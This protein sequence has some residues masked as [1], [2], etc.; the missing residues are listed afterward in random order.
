[1]PETCLVSHFARQLLGI[2]LVSASEPG[3][4]CRAIEYNPAI[5][6][7]LHGSVAMKN[8]TY[9]IRFAI[10]GIST[11]LVAWAG[12]SGKVTLDPQSFLNLDTGVVSRSSGDILWSGTALVPQGSAGVYNL[13]NYGSSR[14]NS[15]SARLA[16]KA[17]YSPAAISADKLATGDIFGV[18]TNSGTYAKVIV[19]A[20]DGN[21][22]SLE[23]TTFGAA[24]PKASGTIA[25]TIKMVQNN[26]SYILP[27]M[28]NYGIAP[29]TLF[30]VV[31]TNLSSS[32]APVLQS[33]APPGLPKSLNQTSISVNVNGVTTNPPLYY[34]SAT[35]LAAVLP[36]T[37]PVGDG[38]ITVS[39]NGQTSATAP[40]H[41]VPGAIGLDTL[42]GTGNGLGLAT[43]ANFNVLGLTR[44]ATPGQAIT[45]WGSGIGADTA[46]D[47][48]TYPQK[49]NNFA[50]KNGLQFFVGGI[51]ATVSYAGRSQYPGLDQYNIVIPATVTSGCFVS[52]V[53]M[54]ASVVSNAV[55]VPVSAS[56]GACTDPATGLTGTQLQSFAGKTN[57]N[58]LLVSLSETLGSNGYSSAL[59]IAPV[60]PGAAFGKGYEYASQGSC[61]I[62][63][64]QQ[65]TIFNFL[66]GGLDAG[67]ALQ[68]SGPLGQ[69]TMPP[70]LDIPGEYEAVL[71]G[72]LTG[73]PGAY[74]VSGP[75]GK[76]AGSFKTTINV[77][78]APSFTNQ[79]ALASITRSQGATVTWSGGYQGGTVGLEGSVGGAFGTVRFFCFA[80]AAAGQFTIPP[81][82][83]MA[84]APG[85]GDL[86]AYSL[87]A[88]QP[89]TATGV[90]IGIAF[91]EAGIKMGAVFK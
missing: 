15:I 75:G 86:R 65:G 31:G 4:G 5:M 43:D 38:T 22:L 7:G 74:T 67:V 32:A 34:T 21:S 2:R 58:A 52:V 20:R 35:Q 63:P 24:T 87:T 68:L 53:A 81:S 54:Q 29:G 66:A 51:E 45:L 27:G 89:I 73:A 1:M 41:V 76:T 18:H 62:V 25:P 80:P 85:V 40:I 12:E 72:S 88:P 56:G 50:G 17:P 26:Y 9:L 11:V 55:T 6:N 48:L 10:L 36:S 13:G 39:Y 59:A 82:I 77:T 37:T 19:S 90:D 78:G 3:I 46:N 44:S 79:Q 57:V 23:F 16:A 91:A 60:I 70:Q 28:P 14:F 33:S 71:A 8:T 84:M 47:D 64:P 30:I 61:T 83:L 49:Q 69:V 42:Y